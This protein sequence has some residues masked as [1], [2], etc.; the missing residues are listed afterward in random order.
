MD[1]IEQ[2]AETTEPVK[3]EVGASEV[4]DTSNDVEFSDTPNEDVN[5]ADDRKQEPQ[6][7][8]TPKESEK[9]ENKPQKTNSDY[10]RERRKAERE[11]ELKK[12]RN[13]AIIE[14]LGGENPYTHEKMEDEADVQEYLTMKEIEKSGIRYY[15][16][17][18]KS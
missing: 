16:R 17:L 3:A 7:P 11:A 5:K 2:S 6:T 4:A 12:V 1:N 10:A 9:K 15:I 18:H 8:N 14:T 13:E